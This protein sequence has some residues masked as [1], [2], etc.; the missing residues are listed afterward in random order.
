MGLQTAAAL[1]SKAFKYWD[2]FVPQIAFTSIRLSRLSVPNQCL[3]YWNGVISVKIMSPL[4]YK[5]PQQKMTK[6]STDRDS[7]AICGY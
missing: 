5:A 6:I 2:W 4:D 1:S 7:K 3:H